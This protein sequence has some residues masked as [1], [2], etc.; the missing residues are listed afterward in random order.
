MS[1]NEN[2]IVSMENAPELPELQILSMRGNNIVNVD[3]IS[4]YATLKQLDLGSNALASI[5]SS[6][7]ALTSLEVLTLKGNKIEAV[8]GGTLASL[9]R[10]IVPGA[11][12]LFSN[13][14][15]LVVIA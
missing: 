13:L 12:S 11:R 9:T 6:M 10:Y 7:T 14:T 15:F 1:L 4:K 5:P 2:M 8:Y 3:A